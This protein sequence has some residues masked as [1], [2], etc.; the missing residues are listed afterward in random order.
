LIIQIFYSESFIYAYE[1]LRWQIMGIFLRVV[2]WPLGFVLLAKGKGKIFFWTELTANAVHISLV[3]IGITLF[4]LEGTG[5]AFFALYAFYTV[6]IFVVVNHVSHL[7]WSIASLRVIGMA[8]VAVALAFFIPLFATQ[9]IALASGTFLTLLS[10]VYALRVIY[11][12][13]GPDWVSEFRNK[14]KTHLGWGE[15]R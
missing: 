2:S 3:W 4:G 13:V 10:A 1:V 9:N 7:K 8:S 11:R 5:I 6:M 14:L 12:L 15:L